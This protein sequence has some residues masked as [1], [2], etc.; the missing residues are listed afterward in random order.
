MQK[1]SASYLLWVQWWISIFARILMKIFGL[2]CIEQIGRAPR[3]YQKKFEVVCL[4]EFGC[5]DWQHQPVCAL[6]TLI[7][8]VR[9]EENVVQVVIN[10]LSGCQRVTMI[11]IFLLLFHYVPATCC[12]LS[13]FFI[14]E[15]RWLALRRMMWKQYHTFLENSNLEIQKVTSFDPIELELGNSDHF[16]LNKQNVSGKVQLV[17][18]TDFKFICWNDY[19]EPCFDSEV[20]DNSFRLIVYQRTG[21]GWKVDWNCTFL[22]R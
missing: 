8:L 9:E 18:L 16:Y 4:V 7:W 21:F 6:S 5:N 13:I 2:L 17:R 14:M 10:T 12:F 11:P 20:Y 15:R 19:L 3:W 22:L 1:S